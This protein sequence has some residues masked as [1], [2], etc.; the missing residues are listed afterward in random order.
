MSYRN[1]YNIK[2]PYATT[3]PIKKRWVR[4]RCKLDHLE[5]APTHR[6]PHEQSTHQHT[7]CIKCILPLGCTYFSSFLPAPKPMFTAR[8]LFSMNILEMS[9]YEQTNPSMQSKSPDLEQDSPGSSIDYHLN[10]YQQAEYMKLPDAKKSKAP[11]PGDHVSECPLTPSDMPT[12][13][14]VMSG[15]FSPVGGITPSADA[16]HGDFC[17]R[18][19][20]DRAQDLNVIRLGVEAI[21]LATDQNLL[22]LD[23]PISMS[24]LLNA[25]TANPIPFLDKLEIKEDIPPTLP[26]DRYAQAARAVSELAVELFDDYE[27][28]DSPPPKSMLNKTMGPLDLT[29]S[30][31]VMDNTIRFNDSELIDIS[32]EQQGSK[33]RLVSGKQR[34]NSLSPTGFETETSPDQSLKGG[35]RKQISPTKPAK[36]RKAK[37]PKQGPEKNSWAQQ[38]KKV[39]LK[40][41]ESEAKLPGD[42]E[43]QVTNC[44]TRTRHLS[45]PSQLVNRNQQATIL[46]KPP[47]TNQSATPKKSRRRH[48]ST[49]AS[50][51]L[52]SLMTAKAGAPSPRSDRTEPAVTPPQPNLTANH[53]TAPPTQGKS[54]PVKTAQPQ[55]QKF[56]NKSAKR[57]PTSHFTTLGEMSGS[58][59]VRAIE[60]AHPHTRGH[61][62]SSHS[63]DGTVTLSSSHP[64]TIATLKG[65]IQTSEGPKQARLKAPV[66][67][68]TTTIVLENAGVL[69]SKDQIRLASNYP[70]FIRFTQGPK[71]R[72]STKLAPVEI[73]IHAPDNDPKNQIPKSIEINGKAIQPQVLLGN[74]GICFRCNRTNHMAHACRH[75]HPTCG[76][77]SGQHATKLCMDKAKSGQAINYKCPMCSEAHP[78]TKCPKYVSHRNKHMNKLKKYDPQYVKRSVSGDLVTLDQYCRPTGHVR[79]SQSQPIPRLMAVDTQQPRFEHFPAIPQPQ[80]LRNPMAK[81]HTKV[82]GLGLLSNPPWNQYRPPLLPN[83]THTTQAP[84]IDLITSVVAQVIRQLEL[85]DADIYR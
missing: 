63:Q 41:L 53:E 11:T 51:L 42:M 3:Q 27:L 46:P 15:A 30:P 21:Q 76:M 26:S 13:P 81:K 58:A 36:P 82:Q 50:P 39:Q 7:M 4:V 1:S 54:K 33:R 47:P 44:P 10:N 19:K 29:A 57:I 6:L 55:P 77:C 12:S 49:Q 20:K 61:I 24:S 22:R 64:Q 78:S 60:K 79:Q 37:G 62:K 14:S 16:A 84:R 38:Q 25:L 69:T 74:S 35:K 32:I 9:S 17:D 59:A 52:K 23:R 83:P 8:L 65:V 31:K 70:Q 71:P 40:A 73:E 43:H 80:S 85:Q 72:S 18:E 75:H 66:K 45:E 56:P 34:E 48:T 5:H 67:G 68:K 28:E 2:I